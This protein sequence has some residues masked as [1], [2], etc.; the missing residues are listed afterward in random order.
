M[1]NTAPHSRP[2]TG[3][4][5]ILASGV[6]LGM[7]TELVAAPATGRDLSHVLALP[8]LSMAD[9]VAATKVPSIK[10]AAA[11]P[12]LTATVTVRKAK[13]AA[14]PKGGI[15]LDSLL[16]GNALP[17][18]E[19]VAKSQAAQAAATPVEP[20]VEP[21]AVPAVANVLPKATKTDAKTV[22]VE[23]A[24]APAPVASAA[25]TVKV[26][27]PTLTASVP[28]K[29]KSEPKL[30][31]EPLALTIVA[32]GAGLKLTPETL[33]FSSIGQT[34]QLTVKAKDKSGLAIF[35]RDQHIAR[36]DKSATRLEALQRG[37]T[38]LYVVA[39]GKMYIVP[40]TIEDTG[41]RWDLAVPDALV[42]LEGVFQG[43]TQQSALFPGMEQATRTSGDADGAPSLQDSIAET[44]R[45]IG[46]AD[47]E[48]T[49]IAQA[50][51]APAYKQI[52]IQLVDER[53]V[54]S[55]ARIY[56]AANVDVHVIGTEFTAKTD[57]TGHLTIRD[58][59]VNSRFMLRLD[60]TSGSSVRPAM[61]ELYTKGAQEA[62]V[63]RIRVLRNFAFDTYAQIAG[64]AQNAGNGS[65]CAT[66]VDKDDDRAPSAGISV[67]LDVA[68]DGPFYFNQYG[69]L[70]KGLRATGPD[71]RVCLFNVP[72][73]PV[74]MSLFTGE[75]YIA[76]LPTAA[77][78]GRHSEQDVLLGDERTLATRLATMATAH[79]QLGQNIRAA[80]AYK[81]IDMIDL[82]PV[83]TQAPMMQL[84]PGYVQTSDSVL[85][86]AGRLFGF[87]QAAEFEPTI[88]S[89]QAGR[90]GNVVPLIPR[91]FVED[92]SVYAQVSHD[93]NLGVVLVEYGHAA[94]DGPDQALS[95]RLLDQYGRD[96]GDGWY[97]ADAPTTKAIFF[98]V[99]AGAY[100]L[101]SETSD[102]N[103]LSGDTVLVYSETVSY[104]RQGGALRY[105]P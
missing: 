30:A 28:E 22:R 80:N 75:S 1:R 102:G 40:V 93:P 25:P 89:F 98:N 10:L 31:A 103:W 88:Y 99:P 27:A 95:L 85:P 35:V 70:D 46:E 21:A 51:A 87:A 19:L 58:V 37:A 11:Q 23:I 92:M 72:S 105:R 57:S 55:Q 66:I 67:S 52:A 8:A 74:A 3:S 2:G 29:L 63:T 54:L 101:L 49:R 16:A 15:P 38:E 76:T 71:G 43:Q 4:L 7:S 61:V 17:M 45:S 9:L 42:S 69:F 47:L 104:V 33:A 96:V 56:P 59:P 34:A 12:A 36:L 62:G 14:V 64:V 79:E 5:L 78:A 48:A 82:I 20:I 18:S 41:S 68:A 77:F 97:Y 26:V 65:L 39:S 6:V 84:A 24:P 13:P 83:G 60:D 73:G 44:A 81:T 91:G 100:S 90:G 53:S 94:K 50:D 32:E 86:S